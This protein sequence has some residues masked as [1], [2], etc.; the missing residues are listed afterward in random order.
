MLKRKNCGKYYHLKKKFFFC[1]TLSQ[2]LAVPLKPLWLSKQ[3]ILFLIAPS[4][5][6][7]AKT[8]Q[9]PKEENLSNT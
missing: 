1:S 6:E 7:C 9:C 4:S 5:Y 2:I 3:R 8:F